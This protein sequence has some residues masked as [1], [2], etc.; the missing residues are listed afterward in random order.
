MNDDLFSLEKLHDLVEPDPVAWWPLAPGWWFVMALLVIWTAAVCMI[1]LIRWRRS[2]Y[3][4]AGLRLLDEIELSA[5]SGAE[6]AR[7]MSSL[8][9]L[10]KRV[11]L[12]AYPRELV[13]SLT[14]IEWMEFLDRTSP[15]V[16]F[17]TEPTNLLAKAS[18][19]DSELTQLD[20][21][22]VRDHLQGCTHLDSNSRCGGRNVLTFAHSWVFLLL[23][24][25]LLIRHLL[26]PFRDSRAAVRIPFFEMLTK[27]VE[28][29][30]SS[31]AVVRRRSLWQVILFIVCWLCV[32]T[33][34]ARPQWLEPPIVREIP[35]R[36]L[37][38]LI[39]LSGSMETEDFVNAT[40]QK[41]DR[42]TA[43]KEVL[44]EFVRR[45]K[46]DRVAMIVFGT[47][48]FVQIPF[49]QDLDVCRELLEQTSPRM[50]GP[51]TALGDAIGL[52]ITLF[53]RSDVEEK[54][55]IALTDG[56]DTGSR[57][58]PAEAARIAADHEITIYTIAVG[59]PAAAGEAAIDEEALRDVAATTRGRFYRANDRAD[60][61]QIYTELDQI[62]TREVETISHRPRR[63]LFHWPLAIVMVMSLLYHL[64]YLVSAFARQRSQKLIP[65][66]GA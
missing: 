10:L 66:E 53:E 4:R 8:S 2:A 41:V 63:D 57:V 22:Q 34:A 48:A 5:E 1:A 20:A 60:L 12:A 19:D 30:P 15:T 31:G 32:V 38:L 37:L 23:P 13:A 46:G 47:G 11:A 61:A 65:A 54:V 6:R 18:V 42:L 45:R 14:G 40:G 56:N 64:L 49:T 26:P 50:A 43:V 28:A 9:S 29:K 7:L 59:D 24:L 3:R 62:D 25:P 36:D 17:T 27:S 21:A 52:G 39:D 51:K 33:A 58:P 16:R 55:M 44:D 35:T